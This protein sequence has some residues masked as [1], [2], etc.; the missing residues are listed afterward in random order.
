MLPAIQVDKDRE[1]VVVYWDLVP[2][3][4]KFSLYWSRTGSAGS[5]LRVKKNI[6]NT[7]TYGKSRTQ[8]GFKRKELGLTE[9]DTFYLAITSTDFNSVESDLGVPR[10]IAYL[11]DQ[12]ADAGAMNSP[13]NTSENISQHVAQNPQRVTFTHDAIF[14]EIFNNTPGIVLYVDVTGVDATKEK[15]MPV[16]PYTYY[17]VFRNLSKGNGVSLVS[18]G[19]NAVDVRIVIHY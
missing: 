14:M 4:K 16:Y 12:M 6:P 5:Y 15:S 19:P 3:V 7:P 2:G 9:S 8:S 1:D 18:H 17:T 13:I 11:S 10:I